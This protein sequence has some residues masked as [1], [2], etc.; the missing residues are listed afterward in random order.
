MTISKYNKINSFKIDSLD[1]LDWILKYNSEKYTELE[2]IFNCDMTQIINQY[3][4]KIHIANSNNTIKYATFIPNITDFNTTKNTIPVNGG[5]TSYTETL[6]YFTVLYTNKN[7]FNTNNSIILTNNPTENLD[8]SLVIEINSIEKVFT[9]TNKKIA[10]V[11]ISN[12][13]T[14]SS[15]FTYLQNYNLTLNNYYFEGSDDV[16][17]KINNI[18]SST[19][20]V[21]AIDNFVLTTPPTRK[22]K[23]Q[24]FE[25]TS[26]AVA[27]SIL[28][29]TYSN[30]SDYNIVDYVN[31]FKTTLFIKKL[32]YNEKILINNSFIQTMKVGCDNFFGIQL[33]KNSI[34]NHTVNLEF[35][36]LKELIILNLTSIT[37]SPSINVAFDSTPT[38]T[39]LGN[40]KFEVDMV[41]KATNDSNPNTTYPVTLTLNF[42]SSAG[43]FSL[44]TTTIYT[45]S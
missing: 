43:N 25:R 29:N 20:S 37:F 10:S 31:K 13:P 7:H 18:T 6:P 26:T 11:G 38:I 30:I 36:L 33:N 28:T 23:T 19:L 45:N 32:G 5:L 39:S 21:G 34:I 8:L 1:V 3:V 24:D 17:L 14:P 2:V 4:V 15:I 16:L 40:A 12:I 27:S 9:K 41:Y 22:N 35:P 44:T 42:T